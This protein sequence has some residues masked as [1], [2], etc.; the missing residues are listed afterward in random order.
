MSESINI[1]NNKDIKCLVITE[2]GVI[3]ALGV[4]I[5]THAGP[6]IV[7]ELPEAPEEEQSEI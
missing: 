2:D 5:A 1:N 4:V 7:L 3:T 6:V